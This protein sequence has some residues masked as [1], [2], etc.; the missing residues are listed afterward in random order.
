M[1]IINN[2]VLS[3]DCLTWGCLHYSSLALWVYCCPCKSV[4]F[5]GHTGWQWQLQIELWQRPCFYLSHHRWLW[6]LYFVQGH[7]TYPWR[8]SSVRMTWQDQDRLFAYRL[9]KQWA[10]DV[11]ISHWGKKVLGPREGFSQKEISHS[12]DNLSDH[13]EPGPS[14]TGSTP[15]PRTW[16]G[17]WTSVPLSYVATLDKSCPLFLAGIC[18]FSWPIEDSGWPWLWGCRAQIMSQTAPKITVS[19][20]FSFISDYFF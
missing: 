3:L 14:V 2:L 11:R 6:S 4:Y 8:K 12:S 20:L 16:G 19:M 7:P 15:V 9:L 18:L 5:S 1:S 10:Q 13:L 17:H